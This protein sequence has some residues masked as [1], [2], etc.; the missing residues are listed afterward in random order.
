[1]IF[2]WA[3]K[4]DMPGTPKLQLPKIVV[5]P[6]PGATTKSAKK[7]RPR[8]T[9]GNVVAAPPP[10]LLLLDPD[11]WSPQ[12]ETPRARK[13]RAQFMCRNA[14]CW[15]Q[16]SSAKLRDLHEENCLSFDKVVIYCALICRP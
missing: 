13:Q 3:M 16:F 1:M 14:E 8:K 6:P 5:T 15:D 11:F 12:S 7:M 10:Q 4:K 2:N 9:N